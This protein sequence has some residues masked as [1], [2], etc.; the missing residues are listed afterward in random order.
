V[1]P[2]VTQWDVLWTDV[3]CACMAGGRDAYGSIEDAALAIRGGRIAWIGSRRDL[4]ADATA[5]EHRDGGG[6]W[7]TPALIDCHTHLVFAGDRAAEFEARLGGAS[8]EEIARAGGGILST[9]RATRAASEDALVASALPRARALADEGVGTIEIKS[10]YGLDP[11]TELRMLRA[12]RRVEAEAGVRVRTT[13]LA[14]HA[15]PPEFRSDRAA[16]VR[17]VVDDLLPRVASDSLADAVDVFCET[18]AFTRDECAAV[19]RRA[20]ELGFAVRVHADQLSDG[21]GA[22]LAADFVARSAEHLEYTSEEGVAALAR[23]GTVAVLLPGAYVVLRETQAPPI[24]AMRRHGVPIAI[25]TDCNPGTSP[26]T[27]LLA[28]LPLAAAAFRLTPAEALAGVTRNAARALGLG[29]LGTLEVGKRAEFALWDVTH[30]RELTYWL[31]RNPLTEV[32]RAR[33]INRSASLAR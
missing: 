16:Y 7:I 26:V 15:L 25:A 30:P 10:G 33:T 23:A 18:I 12:A 29:D 17:Q 21:G 27:S 8:Y 28:M 31:G 1:G 3:H 24:D 19:L 6:R 13:C 32:V 4:P 11:D 20:R 14:L 9:V 2:L 22:A 5:S